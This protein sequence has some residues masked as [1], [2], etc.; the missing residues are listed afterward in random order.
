[1]ITNSPHVKKS[2]LEIKDFPPRAQGILA[3]TKDQMAL[4]SLW[5]SKYAM[6]QAVISKWC[7]CSLSHTSEYKFISGQNINKIKTYFMAVFE[8]MIKVPK[9]IITYLLSKI[10]VHFCAF[11]GPKRSK[12]A[13][14]LM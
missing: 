8:V 2:R 10:F 9:V 5:S 4:L 11:S 13:I 1:M 7:I 3:D 6:S 14:F 12:L